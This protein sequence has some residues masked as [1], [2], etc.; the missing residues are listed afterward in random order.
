M[1]I[2]RTDEWLKKDFDRPAK[3]CDRLLPYFKG[4]KTS[5]I[6]NQLLKFGMYRPSW[7]TRKNFDSMIED[8]AWEQVKKLF[9]KY[10]NKWSG[11]DIPIFLFPLE[12]RGGIFF[13]Q[14]ER[15]KA[16]VSFPDKMF[17]FLSHYDD[18]KELEALIVHEYHHVCRLRTLNRK[19][20]D[21]TLLDS[22]IIEGLAEYAVLKNCGEEYLANWC[23]IYTDREILFFWNRFLREQLYTKKNER[24][25][26]ELLYG[27]GRIPSLL[28]YAAG[29]NIVREY[30]NSE[31]YSTKL[32]FNIPA[33]KFI[34]KRNI[35]N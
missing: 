17:L 28:G 10:K 24:V 23:N 35:F 31:N 21:Y 15:N 18:P 7:R 30:Y 20:E 19:M 22:I 4:Q 6:Y 3:I 32:T 5:E 13:R 33:S 25:H 29:Y 14:E 34:K 1:G 9:S 27:G 16:G 8:K 2:I 26:D 12:Q 11:P